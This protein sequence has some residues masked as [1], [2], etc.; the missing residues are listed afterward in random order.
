MSDHQFNELGLDSYSNHQSNL[1]ALEGFQRVKKLCSLS[2][3]SATYH[4]CNDVTYSHAV[5]CKHSVFAD[6]G[7]LNLGWQMLEPKVKL[8]AWCTFWLIQLIYISEIGTT[9]RWSIDPILSRQNTVC[10]ISLIPIKLHYKEH[11]Q[12]D[13]N[14]SKAWQGLI[15]PKN[16]CFFTR[17]KPPDV[18][19]NVF[20]KYRTVW[21]DRKQSDSIFLDTVT[22][23]LHN[24][25]LTKIFPTLQHKYIYCLL[26]KL[27]LIY[28]SL[29][30][31]YLQLQV[32]FCMFLF[33]FWTV[34]PSSCSWW[35]YGGMMFLF[36]PDIFLACWSAQLLVRDLSCT[37]LFRNFF[38]Y[39]I[40]PVPVVE[41]S[42][43]WLG[44]ACEG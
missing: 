13:A 15:L 2:K 22:L 6:E 20:L 14:S 9:K 8:M 7:S 32:G 23:S 10:S 11:N 1:I 28:C 41:Q 19:S 36:L 39:F 33:L 44:D 40:L 29:S 24:S 12:S 34:I 43:F 18:K 21:Q 25:P 17:R 31:V 35:W 27:P 38:I 3:A 30:W 37:I 42:P 26:Q 4:I 5:L 16:V